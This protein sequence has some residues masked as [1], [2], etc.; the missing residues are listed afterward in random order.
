MINSTKL[1]KWQFESIEALNNIEGVTPVL[2]IM[3]EQTKTIKRSFLKRITDYK[4]H[5]LWFR[6]YYR[7]FFRPP[8]FEESELQ[9]S[10]KE[11]SVLQCST[12]TKGFSEF[13]K[14]EDIDR[15]RE[16]QPDFIL[17]FG[18]GIIKGE[19]LT[20]TPLGVWSFHH[21]D[22]Q[23]YRGVPPALWE[24][25]NNDHKTG[26]I[27]QRLTNKLDSG[28][29]LRK[30]LFKTIEHSWS[31]NLD[32]TINLSKKWPA[33][34]CREIIAQGTFPDN[35][36][37]VNTTAPLYKMPGNTSFFLFLLKLVYN[38]LKF[39]YNELTLCEIWQTGLLKARTAEIISEYPFSI[40]PNEVD[41]PRATNSDGYLA[42]G[43]ALKQ[44]ERLLLLFEDYT[45]K[46]RKGKISA[47]WYSERNETF[48]KPQVLLD[49]PWHLS[50]PYIFKHNGMFWC[51]PECKD[52]KN[53]ELYRLDISS[54]KL[55]HERTLVKD[56]E[57]VDPTLIFHNNHWYLFFT[58]GYASN[59][60][61]HIWHAEN[62][63]D[64][65]QPHVLTPVKADV[66]NSRPAGSPFYL[67]GKL[68]RPA[69]DC[70]R[71]YGGRIILNEIKILSE[72][73]FL[74]MAANVLE[75]PPSF[76][77]LHNISFAGDYMFFDCKLMK[78]SM[79][80]FSYQLKRKLRLIRE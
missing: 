5:Y 28:V 77:G 63:E 33:D 66:S 1:Q 69:Q 67:D 45:Y 20:C 42:D 26:A 61:L 79:A 27:L 78:F 10:L 36:D 19:I 57:A 65:F 3:P 14:S 24:I 7:Y 8:C 23:K 44:N 34:V 22:E 13:F 62:L 76:K 58:A 2:I 60:E 72:D 46:G 75:P 56:L 25:L 55:V 4:W 38:K 49:E 54:M 47:S 70:S 59:V 48:T 35:K 37:G 53:V 11:L 17:K 40:N 6:I 32:Q 18:F 43:F 71:S 15:I 80:N 51:I 50:Y 12:V 68:Y 52:H 29:I 64:D 39:H 9:S 74:E 31:A 21:G 41:W 30:G 73:Y 16:Y